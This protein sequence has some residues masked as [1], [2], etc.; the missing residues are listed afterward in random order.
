MRTLLAAI[1]LLFFATFV[2]GQTATQGAVGLAS[3]GTFTYKAPIDTIVPCWEEVP[4]LDTSHAYEIAPGYPFES[5]PFL[6]RDIPGWSGGIR[7]LPNSR[8]NAPLD[9]IFATK[10]WGIDFDDP[11]PTVELETAVVS[12]LPFDGRGD[13]EDYLEQR[14]S[15]RS[16]RLSSLSS[17]GENSTPGHYRVIVPF[18]D[19]GAAY[20]YHWDSSSRDF[21]P[22]ERVNVV[23]YPF[24]GVV[25]EAEIWHPGFNKHLV[26]LPRIISGDV[27]LTFVRIGDICQYVP[28]NSIVPAE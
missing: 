25:Q 18:G 15:T 4:D 6:Y 27:D 17:F 21:S 7:L 26:P 14:T 8:L 20:I 28:T 13:Q 16:V 2:Q 1:A 11:A 23:N 12:E 3:G 22:G 24:N 19:G 5:S 10:Q 9:T